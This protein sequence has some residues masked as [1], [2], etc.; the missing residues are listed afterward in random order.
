[1]KP[2]LLTTLMLPLFIHTTKSKT[3][4]GKVIMN[5][6][7]YRNIHHTKSNNAK[8]AMKEVVLSLNVPRLGIGPF[9]LV[10]T[11]YH[12]NQRKVDVANTCSI[13]DKFTC[14]ALTESNVWPDDNIDYVKEVVYKW[15]GVDPNKIGYCILDIYEI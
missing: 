3:T 1:M 12:G 10:Y 13:I 4:K 5:L 15:G 2:K 14:D 6:N 8:K 7:N 11:Y 9:K